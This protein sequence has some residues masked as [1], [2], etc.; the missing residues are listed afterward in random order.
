MEIFGVLAALVLGVNAGIITGLIPGV[1]A[2]LVSV[3]LVS[4]SPLL[5]IYTSPIVLAVFII[6]LAIT[7]TFLDAIPSIYLGAPTDAQAL[8]VLPG[9]RLLLKGLGHNAIIYTVIGALG[10]LL[11]S[12]LLFPIFIISMEKLTSIVSVIVAYLLIGVMAYMILK[13]QGKRLK[14]LVVF[15][16]SGALGL[17]VFSIPNLKQPLFPL[18]KD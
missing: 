4:F 8:N 11:L 2:N 13:D 17:L 14:A 3:L 9:H 10:S 18:L 1:H 16:L 7:H 6:S 12:V 5:L 15:L